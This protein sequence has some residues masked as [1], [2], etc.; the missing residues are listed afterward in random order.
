MNREVRGRRSRLKLLIAEDEDIIRKGIVKYIKLHTERYQQIYEAENGQEAIDLLLKYQPELLLLDV[1]MPLKNGIEVMQAAKNAGLD[2]VIVILSG[3]DEFKYAQ[4]ALRYGAKE[5]LLKPVRASDILKCLNQ[6]A[7]KYFDKG[8]EESDPE[9]AESTNYFIKMA[10]E[11]IAEH[12]TENISLVD[13]AEA[14]GISAGYLSTMFTQYLDC[15]FVDYLN[16]VR[17]ERACCYLEQK[18]FK[19][20]EVAFKVGFRDEKYFSKVFK[21]I[22]G[23]TPREY[24]N[25]E[26]TK[27]QNI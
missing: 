8:K 10:K 18:C 14:A 19:N 12:Y 1:Q 5:Y 24:R 25:Q 27:R 2:P 13:A 3:H 4:Q 6:M 20:Y 26:N 16:Q 21:K 23:M 17:I 22:M 11:Y 7:D 9:D 15:G